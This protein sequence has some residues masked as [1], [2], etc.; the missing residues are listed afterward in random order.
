MYRLI[1]IFAIALFLSGCG[2]DSGFERGYIISHSEAM[3]QVPVDS[4]DEVD[5]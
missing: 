1:F 3:D 2:I 5:E 4:V